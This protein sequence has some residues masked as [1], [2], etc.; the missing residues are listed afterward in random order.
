L[1]S[2]FGDI[3]AE[4]ETRSSMRLILYIL[5]GFLIWAGLGC[6]TPHPNKPRA[7]EIFRQINELNLPLEPIQREELMAAMRRINEAR[8]VFPEGRKELLPDVQLGQRFFIDGV[9]RNKQTVVLYEE[10][11]TLG[12]SEPDALCASKSI[13]DQQA[14]ISHLEASLKEFEV[15]LD[16]SVTDNKIYNSKSAPLAENSRKLELISDASMREKQIACSKT[17]LG[18]K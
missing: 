17:A 14:S 4:G 9:K 12:L 3:I 2:V 18:I 15:F 6:A 11:L 16:E 5:V 8:K 7:D 1:A 13:K 10:L